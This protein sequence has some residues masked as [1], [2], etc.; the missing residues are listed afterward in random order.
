MKRSGLD[1]R[2]PLMGPGDVG[3]APLRM[4]IGWLFCL[5]VVFPV[6]GA[7]QDGTPP[8]PD[9]ADI[10][11]CL[12]D[13][14]PDAICGT[15]QDEFIFCDGT[16]MSVDDVL[17]MFSERYPLGTQDNVP[18]SDPG[19]TRYE[20]L[21]RKLYGA[22]KAAVRA[23]LADV[24]WLPGGE[25]RTIKVNQRH[26]AAKQLQR[27]SQAL[28]Q[29]PSSISSRVSKTSGTFVWRKIRGTRRLSMHSFA[30]ALDVGVGQ[31]A[32]FWKWR[33]TYRNRIP[34]E[35]VEIFERHG[36]IWGGKWKHFDT[37]H[38]EYRPELLHPRCAG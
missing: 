17:P 31:Y 32:D 38:F 27:V 19:R 5:V 21:F 9:R 15:T 33:R 35:V 12:Q 29:L 8:P 24:T 13:S 30:I 23:A 6:E 2:R 34:L 7:A 28:E 36:F 10:M 14:Y 26:A 37:M 20:P 4:F 3:G 1:G 22:D 16:R 11:V 25:S 18:E